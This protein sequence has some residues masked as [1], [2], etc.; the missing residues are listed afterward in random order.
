MVSLTVVD[1]FRGVAESSVDA[2]MDTSA[3][4]CRVSFRIGGEYVVYATRS[5]GG[6]L[7]IVCPRTREV[8]D[9]GSDLVVRA[10]HSRRKAGARLR[11]RPR[12]C[13]SPQP[14]REDRWPHR[15]RLQAS[16][17]PSRVTRSAKLR[18]RTL[19]AS[20]ASR[21]RRAGS[22]RVTVDVPQR[23]YSSTRET[24]V[25]INDPRG[26][27]SVSAM[28]HDDGRVAGRVL[29]T[30]GTPVAGLTIEVGVA[31]ARGV[32]AVTDRN[33]SYEVSRLPAGRYTVSIPPAPASGNGTRAVR[34]FHPGVDAPATGDEG[35]AHRWSTRG[36][37]RPQASIAPGVRRDLWRCARRHWQPGRGRPHLSQGRG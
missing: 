36:S 34:V 13:K 17:S 14:L 3:S 22:Y 1:G 12:T 2:L 23:F 28:L 5:A 9:A 15:H 31:S 19:A 37:A 24:V 32:R 18:S 20:F 6:G 16:P 21:S 26:C 10:R 35:Y 29:D 27:A 25:A 4:P 7:S 11:R 8:E 30:K 33:G